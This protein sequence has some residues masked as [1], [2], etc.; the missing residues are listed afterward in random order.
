M[1]RR[2]ASTDV[3]RSAVLPADHFVT[4][5][6]AGDVA[7]GRGP[8]AVGSCAGTT[9]ACGSAI[10]IRSIA[11]RRLGGRSAAATCRR[12]SAAS[13]RSAASWGC[14][15]AAAS[16][17]RSATRGGST[18]RCGGWPGLR[19]GARSTLGGAGGSALGCGCGRRLRSSRR[20]GGRGFDLWL[21]LGARD[22][23]CKHQHHHRSKRIH[24]NSFQS[25]GLHRAMRKNY[26]TSL[27]LPFTNVTLMSG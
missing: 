27:T 13:G 20:F 15:A 11:Y 6:S 5:G 2:V 25:D 21:V 10:R 19:S 9:T 26:C 7:A 3:G 24:T 1:D 14:S 23:S 12:R 17:S 22:S 16:G 18:F 4:A 8:G